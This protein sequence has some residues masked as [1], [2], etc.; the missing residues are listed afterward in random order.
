MDSPWHLTAQLRSNNIFVSSAKGTRVNRIQT[1]RLVPRR[2][3]VG[4]VCA[5]YNVVELPTCHVDMVTSLRRLLLFHQASCIVQELPS[6]PSPPI[7]SRG[8]LSFPLRSDVPTGLVAA[9]A[10]RDLAAMI[11]QT[12]FSAFFGLLVFSYVQAAKARRF[13]RSRIQNKTYYRQQ[14]ETPI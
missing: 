10:I 12:N 2:R 8:G 5:T 11:G 1:G 3:R 9:S 7:G 13:A 14:F 4:R 6:S